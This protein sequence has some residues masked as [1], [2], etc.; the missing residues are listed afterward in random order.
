[1]AGVCHGPAG[2][3]RKFADAFRL[4]SRIV[5]YQIYP[6]FSQAFPPIATPPDRKRGSE[7]PN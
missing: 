6:A 5:S 7:C 1:M 2:E 4:L 3:S